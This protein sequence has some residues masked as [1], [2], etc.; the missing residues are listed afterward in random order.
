MKRLFLLLFAVCTV[1]SLTPQRASANYIQDMIKTVKTHGSYK[2]RM[3]ALV[4]L[5]NYKNPKIAKLLM[6]VLKDRRQH[7]SVRGMAAKL[8]VSMNVVFAIPLFRKMYYVR[9]RRLRRVIRSAI[10][11]MC[12]R[13]TRGKKYYVNFELAKGEGPNSLYARDLAVMEFARYLMKKRKD[14]MLGWSRCRRPKKWM[15][16]RRRIKAYYINIRIQIRKRKKGGTYGNMSLLYT[17]FP[18][19][20]IK[21]MTSIEART[22]VQPELDVVAFL[23]KSLVQGLTSSVDQ[24][25]Q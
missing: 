18:K 9:N 7:F 8:L 1:G 13:S 2:V 11:D 10:K 17:S 22:P 3:S 23:T 16:R 19:N 5:S 24:F 25:L 12:P 21:G 20:A 14:V 6:N 15:L 4:A